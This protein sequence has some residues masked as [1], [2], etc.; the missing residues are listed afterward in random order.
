MCLHFMKEGLLSFY[1]FYAIFFIR[2][3]NN[4]L[5][6]FKVE[7]PLKVLT[8]QNHKIQTFFLYRLRK[9]RISNKQD[10]ITT[11]T[12]QRSAE[13]EI[14]RL[15]I[16]LQNFYLGARSCILYCCIF[17]LRRWTPFP[18]NPRSN[19]VCPFMIIEKNKCFQQA[20][21][22]SGKETNLNFQKYMFFLF[23]SSFKKNV[24]NY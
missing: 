16:L 24:Y 21:Q 15:H 14:P 3:S 4:N 6:F 2:I 9:T 8:T 22:I 1:Y 20:F 18:L 23:V 17:I 11:L 10:R 19:S 13:E 7:N 5:A 12:L